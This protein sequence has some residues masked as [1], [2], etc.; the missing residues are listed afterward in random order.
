MTS[1]GKK[2][3]RD[4]DAFAF[5]CALDAH[6]NHF[7]DRRGVW[8]ITDWDVLVVYNNNPYCGD[9]TA[10]DRETNVIRERLAANGIKELAYATYPPEGKESA[11]YT[12][13]MVLDA[14]GD[15]MDWVIETVQEVTKETMMQLWKAKDD[16]A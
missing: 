13:A 10:R 7:P 2:S 3:D 11:G 16:V 6:E 8:H 4:W 12:Y 5:E 9:P 1:N 14:R 15:Q